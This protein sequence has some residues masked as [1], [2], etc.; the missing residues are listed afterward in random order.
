MAKETPAPT[1]STNNKRPKPPSSKKPNKQFKPNNQQKSQQS[2]KV[3][4]KSERIPPTKQHTYIRQKQKQP[5]HTDNEL[6]P[7][8]TDTIFLRNVSRFDTTQESLKEHMEENFGKTVYCLLCEDKETGESKGTAFVKF[9]E[10]ETAAKCLEEFKDREKQ[11]KFF[12]DGRNLFVLP[13][14]TRN[15]VGEVKQ[16]SAKKQDKNVIKKKKFKKAR[17]HRVP[18]KEKR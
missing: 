13:A 12:L 3:A 7:E 4:M 5:K 18:T 14:L 10:P 9:K 1:A 8:L 15:Q 17:H 11:T 2:N 16:A 6:E